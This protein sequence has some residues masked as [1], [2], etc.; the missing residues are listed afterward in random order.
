MLYIGK[1]KNNGDN[2]FLFG[3]W[4]EGYH[5]RI[6]NTRHE[7]GKPYLGWQHLVLTGK[8]ISRETDLTLYHNGKTVWSK[9]LQST[10]ADTKGKGWT[11]GQEWD[12]QSRGDY[13]NADLD[14]LAFFKRA[15][16]KNEVNQLFRDYSKHTTV[17]LENPLSAKNHDGT[18][19][20]L[21]NPGHKIFEIT[22]DQFE[23]KWAKKYGA[24]WTDKYR[25]SARSTEKVPFLEAFSRETIFKFRQDKLSGVTL[26]F[27][28]K[29]DHENLRE[30]KFKEYL[31]FVVNTC[32]SFF[33]E[34]PK[35]KPNAGITKN[36]L[37]YWLKVPYLYKLEYSFL[38]TKKEFI[39]EYVKLSVSSG[40]SKINAVNVDQISSNLLTNTELKEKVIRENDGSVFLAGVPMVDQG[41]KGYCAC[42]ATARVLNYYGREIDQ[43]DIA[44][45][46][47]TT[48][49]TT[50]PLLKKALESISA[51]FRLNVSSIVKCYLNSD[52]DHKRLIRKLQFAYKR[53]DMSFK[54]PLKSKDLQFVFKEMAMTDKRFNDFKRGIKRS[55]DQGKPI[56]WA[57][58][59]GVIPEP[60]IPQARGGHMRLIIGYNESTD[61][62][63][64]T[65][66][67]GKG[68][69]KKAM[70]MA[71]AF[72]VSSAIWEIRPR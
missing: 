49:G 57:L 44:K 36:Y 61:E 65:D 71:S 51:K 16:S 42:A 18:L 52:N 25:S 31:S 3:L 29:G 20:D 19:Q 69:E 26:V 14:E 35:F 9:T 41:D 64:Y 54:S 7:A 30:R 12:G 1:H 27:Y 17:E 10:L 5:V 6:R 60:E 63:Y 23:K 43:H 28:N 34:K 66:S 70:C 15:L 8:V 38:K 39:G 53:H 2:I 13:L 46:A 62:I 11:I 40:N 47:Q 72:F 32:A 50:L 21:L 4:A 55:I 37:Y 68:H 22:K 59:L 56:V 67:W 24:V 33:G 45:I 58:L 48:N